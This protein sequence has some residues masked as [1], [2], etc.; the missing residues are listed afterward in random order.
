[1][2]F[3]KP[4][5]K[6]VYFVFAPARSSRRDYFHSVALSKEDATRAVAALSVVPFDEAWACR[7]DLK[8]LLDDVGDVKM[9]DFM[10]TPERGEHCAHY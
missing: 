3:K 4:K 5:K 6:Y 2:G 9:F 7:V 10:Y 1:V 8:T